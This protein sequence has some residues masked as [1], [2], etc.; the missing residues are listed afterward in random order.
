MKHL[1][2]VAEVNNSADRWLKLPSRDSIEILEDNFCQPISLSDILSI[3]QESAIPSSGLQESLF[4]T[5]ELDLDISP[6]IFA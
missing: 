4:G 5:W 3:G 1:D 6:S 2:S